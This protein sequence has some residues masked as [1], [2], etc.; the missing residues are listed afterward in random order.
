MIR[1][2]AFTAL[3]TVAAA[4]SKGGDAESAPTADSVES[5][6][7]EPK[8]AEAPA[9]VDAPAVVTESIALQVVGM[10]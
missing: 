5:T 6:T 8:A 3:L 10:T 9:P 2:L 1:A 7:A 4:C